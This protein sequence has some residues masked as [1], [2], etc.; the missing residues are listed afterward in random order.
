MLRGL[1]Y[2]PLGHSFNPNNMIPPLVHNL[3]VRVFPKDTHKRRYAQ[4]HTPSW[5]WSGNV[6]QH[7][8]LL[9]LHGVWVGGQDQHLS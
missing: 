9:G 7:L 4:F 1:L 8:V 2:S 3:E 5:S 6:S